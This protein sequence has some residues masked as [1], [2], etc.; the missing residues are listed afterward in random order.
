VT[1]RT[2]ITFPD[3]AW[4]VFI[5]AVIALCCITIALAVTR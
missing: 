3:W 5:S 4:L 2:S 1:R